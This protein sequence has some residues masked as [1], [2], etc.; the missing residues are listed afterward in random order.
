MKKTLL[1]LLLWGLCSVLSQAI[2]AVTL[3]RLFS[4]HMVL[5]R[6]KSAPVWGWAAPNE[7]IT[8]TLLQAPQ[9]VQTITTKAD[10]KGN[11]RINLQPTQA[12][13]PYQL[14]VAGKSNTIVLDDVLFGEVWICSGQS[15]M[16]WTVKASANSEEEIKN[17]THPLIRHFEVPRIMATTPKNDLPSGAWQVASPETVGNFTAVGYYFARQLQKELNV[18]IGLIN[19]SWGGTIIETWISKEG[20]QSLDE[21]TEHIPTIPSSLE[22]LSEREKQ[23]FLNELHK[24][25]PS[26]PNSDQTANWAPNSFDYS[27]WNTMTLPKRIDNIALGAFNGVVWFKRSID[28]PS[29][30]GNQPLTISLGKVR[31]VSQ[32]YFNGEKIGEHQKEYTN[33][34]TYVVPA[35]LVKPGSNTISLRIDNVQGNGGFF[36]TQEWLFVA[37]NDF[38]ASLAGD[39]KYNVE[40]VHLS[41]SYS[42][43]NASSTLLFNAM[44]AP[45][46]PFAIQG[47][48]WYQGESNASRAYQYRKAFPLMISDWR[49]HWKE[50]FP[51]LFVQLAGFKASGGNSEK[52]S[53]WAELREAQTMTLTHSPK[54]GMAVIAEI[55]ESGDIHPLN[56]QDVGLRLAK[57]A[58][59]TAY[60]KSLVYSGPLYKAMRTENQKAVVSFEHV[61]SGLKAGTHSSPQGYLLGFEIAGSDQRFYPAQA[62]I[63]GNEVVVW[64]N[65]V[66]QPVAVRYGWYDDNVDINLYNQENLPASPFRTD[67]W[68]SVTEKIKFK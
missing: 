67:S 31:D 65:Q 13:G 34:R 27:S 63:R 46:I 2:A 47:A 17:G 36:S 55:G 20:M 61:G 52:G 51:F 9:K 25:H 40:K 59:H 44:I 18:P 39:W 30:A 37:G 33:E 3:P 66:T 58:L 32:V 45:L 14:S 38:H 26:I 22:E 49:Q 42:S 43:P 50:D 19:T 60:G 54:T 21:F 41:A 23:K 1:S 56:K 35:N 29:Q 28:I 12:G 64:S 6:D 10:K 48:I 15:N 62:V 53:T 11:W 8:V 24:K 5:Q 57:N 16:Q 7:K 4:N 68:N